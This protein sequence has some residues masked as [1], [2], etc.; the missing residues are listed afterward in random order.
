MTDKGTEK[1]TALLNMYCKISTLLMIQV[2]THQHTLK[3]SFKEDRFLCMLA[4]I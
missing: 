4:F 2:N 3:L 1:N